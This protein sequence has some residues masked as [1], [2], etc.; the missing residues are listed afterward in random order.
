MPQDLT[1]TSSY[2]SFV[3]GIVTFYYGGDAAVSGDTELQ[4]WVMDI[5][6]NGFL[7]RTSSGSTPVAAT[8][9]PQGRQRTGRSLKLLV[10]PSPPR[11]SLITADSGRAH[12]VPHHGDVHLLGAACSCQQWA[13]GT[14]A[15][16]P[17]DIPRCL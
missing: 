17:K 14:W 9:C 6:T 2:G 13:G 12:Q 5:F 1:I 10:V 15:R 4:A 16:E 7:G 8:G 3:T 11:Y